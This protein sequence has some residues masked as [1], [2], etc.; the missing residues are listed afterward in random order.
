MSKKKGDIE[1]YYFP[2][3]KIFNYEK[4]QILN[5]CAKLHDIPEQI[6]YLKDI[7]ADIKQRV[8]NT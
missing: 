4:N 6:N 2:P 5:N 1:Q 3:D 7:L 8:E